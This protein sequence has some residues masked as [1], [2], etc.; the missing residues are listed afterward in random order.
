MS[1]RRLAVLVVGLI[2]AGCQRNSAPAPSGK[3]PSHDEIAIARTLAALDNPTEID[4]VQAPLRDIVESLEI[5]H[6]VRIKLD[7]K[8]L[9]EAGLTD[10]LPITYKVK[11]ISLKNAL[12]GML[13]NYGLTHVI[14]HGIVVITTAAK[15]KAT[16]Q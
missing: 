12:T 2:G 7:S 6:D 4:C 3:Q 9:A 5:R 16:V 15:A 13:S 11:G 8:A 1:V 14:D 10:D